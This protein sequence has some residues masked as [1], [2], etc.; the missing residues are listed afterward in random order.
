MQLAI[1]TKLL[2]TKTEMT[3]IQHKKK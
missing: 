2:F 1:I 3:F